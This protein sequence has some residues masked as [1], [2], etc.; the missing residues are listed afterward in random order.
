VSLVPSF[1]RNEFR[2]PAA[3]FWP[4]YFWLWNGPLEP[5]LLRA[6][7][8][9][10]AGHGARSV[11]MLPMPHGF[12][13]GSANNLM[14]PDYL[15]A[16]YFDRV[17]I[18]MEEA[19]RLGMNWWLY[20][21]GGWPSGRALGKVVENHPELM[22]Q[23]LAHERIGIASA[24]YTVPAEAFALVAEPARR[25]LKP[26]EVWTPQGGETGAFL[27]RV[28]SGGS[29]NLLNPESVQRFVELTHEGYKRAIGEFFNKTVHFTFTDEPA[30]PPPDPGKSL[31]WTPGMDQIW[32]ERYGTP[33]DSALPSFFMEPGLQIPIEV[34]RDRICFYDLWTGRFRDS[35]FRT[36][37]E[38]CRVNGLA[39]AGHLG[40]E[41]ATI[42]AV[43]HGFGHVMRPLRTM[44]VPGVDLIWRQIFPGDE[45]PRDFPLFAAS[46]A[47]Q[48]GTRYAFTESFCVYGNGLT[49]AQMKW[50]TDC[51]YVR[52]LN[53]LVI[54]CFPLSTTDHHMTG[55]RPHFGPVNPLWDHLPGYH[56]YVA[57]LGYALSAG[58]PDV[59]TAVYY[60][61][62]DMWAYGLDCE[63]MVADSFDRLV[64]G[65]ISRQCGVDIIDDDLLS[66]PATR[67]EK[68][69]LVAGAM[70]Y[71]TILVGDVRWMQ[72]ESL[73]LLKR[74]ADAG[75]QVFCVGHVP[76]T[77]GVPGPLSAS[78]CRTGTPEAL[79]ELVEP[80]VKADPPSRGLRCCARLL[81]QGRI[82]FL[83]NEGEE[84]YQ[85]EVH[86]ET[87]FVYHLDP[88]TGQ[89][90]QASPGKNRV[91]LHLLP[92]Q[93]ALFLCTGA[94]IET[95]G[96][97][98]ESD[99][100]LQLDRE[101]T[102]KPST[103]FL[104]G[105]HNYEKH[106]PETPP[107]SLERAIQ[108]K[109][110][111]GE[112]FSGEVD[113]SAT[114]TLPETWE[115]RPLRLKTGQVEYAATVF[116]DGKPAGQLLWPPWEIDLPLC[117][118]GTHTLTIRVANTLANEL[119]S[120][121]VTDRWSQKKGTGWPSLYHARALVFE[122]E[123]RGGGLQGPVQLKPR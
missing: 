78:F 40:G 23:R 38:W 56:A 65:L 62:R 7:L 109:D 48:K 32:L 72:T 118:P 90:R 41:D 121:R 108:W 88:Q 111:L 80:A 3:H 49:P 45:K 75:G 76:G 35:Y 105:E 73:A 119:T 39:S 100:V 57:R 27:Y 112:D 71:K 117:T 91:R 25:V 28:S 24:P 43:R 6:Q 84:T 81:D 60:P 8:R 98:S 13:P 82:L 34:A 2:E 51:Q 31:T 115:N 97:V 70:R 54:G 68:G 74:F 5:E 93:S 67:T 19:S 29:A 106:T 50:L 92:G 46:A 14:D 101:I 37:Q 113:Y 53:L 47:H 44:D 61:V 4:G 59:Q 63:E 26:G 120:Q 103:Q 102:V 104:V 12:R 1:N 36:L 89:V 96:E 10:M 33:I 99:E 83:F 30:V 79:A 114:F 116:L 21:E 18:A 107:V 52:G 58:K 42:N 11:A 77:D 16:E 9:D 17:R 20:D 95:E 110:W 94:Q 86:M 64:A 123:S 66:D 122:K 69:E 85:G 15:T 87:D 55:E 22:V